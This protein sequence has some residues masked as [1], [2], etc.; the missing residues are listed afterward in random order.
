MLNSNTAQNQLGKAFKLVSQFENEDYN[1]VN[2]AVFAKEVTKD[3]IPLKTWLN[4]IQNDDP[5]TQAELQSGQM[6]NT[7][8]TKIDV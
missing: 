3:T 5:R 1:G 8:P 6:I 2:D 7:F 4:Y